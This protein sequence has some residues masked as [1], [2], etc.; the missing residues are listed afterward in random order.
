MEKKQ[1]KYVTNFQKDFFKFAGNHQAFS[2]LSYVFHTGDI[3][4]RSVN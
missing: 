4:Q 1:E 3:L 2:Y